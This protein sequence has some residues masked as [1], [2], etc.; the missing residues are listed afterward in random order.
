MY[1]ILYMFMFVCVYVCYICII[2]YMYVCLVCILY[3]HVCLYVCL[4][5]KP[6]IITI[7]QNIYLG[8]QVCIKVYDTQ[9]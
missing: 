7:S 5:F 9:M 6:I 3:M 1:I 4:H 8:R 2:V